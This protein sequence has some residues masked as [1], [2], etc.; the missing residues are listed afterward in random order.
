MGSA[1]CSIMLA[2]EGRGE[3]QIAATQS[4]S[5]AYRKKPALKIGEIVSGRV[6]K[7]RTPIAILAVTADP[8]YVYPDLAR[9]EGLCSLLSV[10]NTARSRA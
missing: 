3:L 1:I 7:E 6:V 10:I 4:L 2:D 5:D 9:D 8:S